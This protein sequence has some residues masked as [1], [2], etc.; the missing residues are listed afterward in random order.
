[1]GAEALSGKNK[2]DRDPRS[3]RAFPAPQS[4]PRDS[5]LAVQPHESIAT[6]MDRLMQEDRSRLIVTDGDR[7][8]GILTRRGLGRALEQLR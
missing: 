7:V 6:V 4:T 5:Q 8:I 3:I 1:M 2:S